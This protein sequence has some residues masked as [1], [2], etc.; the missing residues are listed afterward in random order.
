MLEV[1][2]DR[3]DRVSELGIFT[4]NNNTYAMHIL[5]CESIANCNV[6]QLL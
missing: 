6:Y 1:G 3:A 2:V 4:E 5:I